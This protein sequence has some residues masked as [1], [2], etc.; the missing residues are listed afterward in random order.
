MTGALGAIV[1]ILVA[2]NPPAVAARLGRI[3]S[4]VAG[5]LVLGAGI[6]AVI[7]PLASWL[8]GVLAVSE[9]TFRTAAGAVIGVNGLIHLAGGGAGRRD[10]HPPTVAALSVASP[11]PVFAALAG[12]LDAG[13]PATTAGLAAGVAAAVAPVWGDGEGPIVTWAVRMVGAVAVLAGLALVIDGVS[14]V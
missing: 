11:A 12:T 10:G 3:G 4:R 7:S 5:G 14:T 8:L 13:W 1:T 6:V 9:P 2:L